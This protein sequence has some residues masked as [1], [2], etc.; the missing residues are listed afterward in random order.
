MIKKVYAIAA[1]KSIGMGRTRKG[2][3]TVISP[4]DYSPE[5]IQKLLESGRIEE[6]ETFVP[7]D[8]VAPEPEP[9]GGDDFSMFK[10]AD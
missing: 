9:E 7:D 4:D 10:A 3:G 6:V 5:Q 8:V 2:P 1:G